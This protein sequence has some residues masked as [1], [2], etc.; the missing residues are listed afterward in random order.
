MKELPIKIK[1]DK[2]F[3]LPEERC[4]YQVTA[5]SKQ[6]WAVLL[7]LMV[8]MDGVCKKYGIRYSIDSGTLLG[9]VRHGGFIPWDND[10]DVIMLRSEYN[11]LCEIAPT[12]FRDPYFWQTNETDP[13]SMRP[14]AQLRNSKT[15]CILNDEMENGR[16]RF[17]FN[18]G[19]FLD[20]FVLDEVPDDVGE[21]QA[22]ME[23]LQKS[24]A[25][26][27][28]FKEY[29]CASRNSLW[30]EMAQRQA[31][32]DFETLVSRYNGTGQKR[33]ANISLTPMRKENDLYPKA[34]YQDLVNYSF[35]GFPFP[36]PRDYETKLRGC[37]G[38]WHQFVVGGD[39]HGGVFC[40]ATTSYTHYI[41][42]S[43]KT[44]CHVSS[45][46]EHPIY[47]L[48]KQRDELL[49]Q[50]DEAWKALSQNAKAIEEKELEFVRC[51]EELSCE[52]ELLNMAQVKI[53]RIR[54]E[55]NVIYVICFFFVVLCIFLLVCL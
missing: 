19:I 40:D 31:Y 45:T 16:P 54:K 29:Y 41:S 6:L 15:T 35:E 36:G 10:A 32:R 49:Q 25:M 44:A 7:D 43:P 46:A 23:A 17:T 13:G 24:K 42:A 21:R 55:R 9:A 14:H 51:R 11:R 3:F 8:E 28:D 4:G 2:A 18:Q 48:Y 26:L 39:A 52:K 27:W 20:V 30:M 50:R 12:A 47:R 22:F 1:L 33:V 34:M 53:S 37:Y 5:E 38:D